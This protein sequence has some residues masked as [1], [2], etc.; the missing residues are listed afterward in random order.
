MSTE[1]TPPSAARQL[2]GDTAPKLV[3]LTD[4]VLLGD[5][6]ERPELS[7]RDRSLI[8]VATLVALYRLEQL[9]GH[10]RPGQ[11]PQRTGARRS[12]HAPGL[13][14]R[15]AQR[16]E[17]GHRI[18]RDRRGQPGEGGEMTATAWSEQDLTEI[19]H[20]DEVH[21]ASLRPDGTLTRQRWGR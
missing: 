9:P 4:Q 17:R 19:N 13:L 7:P 16:D 10:L 11:R 14:R 5:V 6:W 18:A 12:D 1:P 20:H 3:E 8:T 21:I 2:I 15:M